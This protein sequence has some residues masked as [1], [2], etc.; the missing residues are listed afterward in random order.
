MSKIGHK[1]SDAVGLVATDKF[2]ADS[3][4]CEPCCSAAETLDGYEFRFQGQKPCLKRKVVAQKGDALFEWCHKKGASL[5][6]ISAD[7]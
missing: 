6:E 7:N 3:G 4:V 5:G 1:G 2:I